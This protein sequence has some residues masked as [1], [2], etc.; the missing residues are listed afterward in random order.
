VVLVAS[1]AFA[2]ALPVLFIS[3]SVRTLVTTPALY[4]YGWWRYDI[5]GRT[6]LGG[7]DLDDIGRQFRTYFTG[8]DELLDLT[9]AIGGQPMSLLTE[10]EVRH[11]ADVK[12]LV[13]RVFAAEW[14]SGIVAAVYVV[15]GFVL[16]RRAFWPLLRRWV[17]LSAVIALAAIVIV[18]VA[19]LIAFDAVFTLFHVVS[20]SNDLWQLDPYR[21]YLLLLFPEAFFLDATIAIALMTALAYGVAVS[22]VGWFER[23]LG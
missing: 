8:D 14:V 23:R 4:D 20:F 2:L 9:V 3:G 13:Q 11:M 17:R 18:A 5:E 7:Q 12:A 16:L 19:S 6:G 21:D 10:R 1:L 22:G 15:G